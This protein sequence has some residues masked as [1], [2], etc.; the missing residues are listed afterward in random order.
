[1][2]DSSV[3]R[4]VKKRYSLGAGRKSI[5]DYLPESSA[6]TGANSSKCLSL[7]EI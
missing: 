3:L 7:T 6:T 1:L 4:I 5:G 2:G